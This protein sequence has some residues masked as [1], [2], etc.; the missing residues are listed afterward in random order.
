[1][2]LRTYTVEFFIEVGLLEDGKPDIKPVGAPVN[3]RASGHDQAKKAAKQMAADRGL[4]VRA[5][6]FGSNNKIRVYSSEIPQ[7][8]V[9]Q[10]GVIN[11]AFKRPPRRKRP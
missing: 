3:V 7:R 4:P 9:P 8:A 6:S 10:S 1:M 2:R 5:I 11:T